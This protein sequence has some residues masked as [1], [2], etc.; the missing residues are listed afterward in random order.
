MKKITTILKNLFFPSLGGARGGYRGMVCH[1]FFILSFFH[2]FILSAQTIG[3]NV[4][5]GGN[6]GNVDGKATVT[7]MGG[8]IQNVFGGARMANVGERTFV[9][10]DGAHA[11]G[12]IFITNVFAGNDIAGTIGKSDELPAQLTEILTGLQTQETQPEKN[13]ISNLWNAFIRVTRN[14]ADGKDNLAVIIGSLYGGGNGDYDY[15]HEHEGGKVKHLVY[16]KNDHSVPIATRYTNEGE[17]DFPRPNLARTYL[18]LKGGLIAHIYGGG[19]NATITENTTISLNNES[20]DLE[21]MLARYAANQKAK[22]PSL[23]INEVITETLDY[24]KSRVQLSNFQADFS[25][26]AFNSAR[27]FGGNNKAPMDIRPTWNLQKGMVRDLYS[28]GNEG[29]MTCPEGLLLE[30]KPT[31]ANNDHLIIQN[32][33]GGCRRANVRPV[34]SN[35]TEV[36]VANLPGYNFPVGLSARTLVRGGKITNVYGGNDISGNVYGGN[37]IG[38]Y[39]SI[40]GDVYGGGNGG[41]FYTDKEELKNDLNYRDFYYSPE[42]ASSYI[43]ALNNFR[44]HAEQVSIYLKGSAEDK[45]TIIGGSVFCGGNCA[46]LETNKL[47]PRVE[48]KIGNHVIADRVFLG[49]NGQ[50]MTDPTILGYYKNHD[51]SSIQLTDPSVFARYMDGVTMTLKPSVIFDADYMDNKSMIGSFYCGGNVGS[52]AIPGKTTIDFDRKLIIYD[53]LVGGCNSADVAASDGLNAAYSG[54]LLGAEDERGTLPN[55]FF[56]ED[57][58][59]GG[60]IKDRLEINLSNI[61]ITPKRWRIERDAYGTYQTDP[62]T[63]EYIRYKDPVT[64][65]P[66]LEWNTVSWND[67]SNDFTITST[68]GS[69]VDEALRLEGG[70]VFGGCY[71]SGHVNGNVIINVNKDLINKDDVF[72]GGKSN[73]DY[74]GQRDDLMVLAM[75]VFGGGYGEETEIW[76]STDINLKNNAYAFQIFGGGVMGVV[77]KKNGI[78]QYVYDERYSTHVNLLGT[79]PGTESGLTAESEYL[80]GGGNEGL[81]CGNS[82]VNLHNG[83]IYDAFGGSSNSDVLGHTEVI[84]GKDGGFPWVRDNIYG[85]NDFGGTVRGAKDFSAV[86]SRPVSD[87]TLLTAATYVRYIQGH[88]GNNI[89]GGNYGSYDYTQPMFN[90]YTWTTAESLPDGKKLGDPKEGFHFPHLNKNSFVHFQPS[91]NSDNAV[92]NAVFGSSEGAAGLT[93]LNNAMQNETYVLIDDTETKDATRFSNMDIFGGGAYAGVG[94]EEAVGAGRTLVDLFAGSFNNVYGGSNQEALIGYTR[95]NVPAESTVKVNALYGGSKG[96]DPAEVAANPILFGRFC[97]TYITCIDYKSPNARVENGIYGGNRNSRLAFDTYIN[98][99]APVYQSNGYM[100]EIYGGGYG[101]ETVS[102][103]TN[104]YMNNGSNAYKVF[105]GGRDGNVFNFTSVTY[106]LWDQFKHEY[107]GDQDIDTKVQA[108]VMRYADF[109]TKFRTYV[110]EPGRIS[111]PTSIPAYHDNI[112]EWGETAA[113]IPALV[114]TKEYHNTNV[115]LLEG[116]N[117]TGYAY[118]G[119]FGSDAVVAGTTYLELKGGNVEK[120]IYGGGQGGPVMD[121]YNLINEPEDYKHFTASTHVYIEGGMARNVYGGGYEGH[122]GKHEGGISDSNAGDIPGATNVIVGT[123]DGTTFLSGIPAIQRNLYGGGEGGSVYGTSNITLNNG[124]IGYRYKNTGTESDPVYEYKEELD[125]RTPNAIEMAGNVFG[126]GYVINSY[127]DNANIDM[128]GGIVRGSMYG[129]GEV[130]P[131]G[132]GTVKSGATTAHGGI[133]NEG[134]TIYKAGKTHVRMFNG[135]VLRNVFGGGRGKD[136]WGGDGTMYMDKDLVATLDMECKGFVFGQ[137]EVDIHGGEIGTDEGMA[138]GYGNVFG[139]C[140]EGTVYSAYEDGNGVLCYGKKEGARYDD[141]YEGYYFK[142]ENGAFPTVSVPGDPEPRRIFTEDCKVLVEPW[143]QV[144]GSPIAYDAKTYNA[145]DYI[146]IG[147]LNTLPA[148]AKDDAIWPSEWNTVDVGTEVTLE[149]DTKVFRERGIHIH[150]AVFAGGNIASGSS[151]LYANAK[152]IFGNATASIHDVYNRDFITIGTGHTGGLYGDGNLT[153]VDGYRELNITNYGSDLY[154][155]MPTLSIGEYKLLPKREQDYYEVKYKCIK[156]EGCSDLEGTTY[157]KD[158][159]LPLDELIALFTNPD[160]TSAKIKADGSISTDGTGTEVLT[161]NAAGYLVVPNPDIWEENGVVSTY[162]GRI[163]NTIQRADFCGVFGSRMVMKGAQDR[164]P[165]TV[166]YTNYTINRVREV[167]LNKM[168]SPASD[169]GINALHGNYFGIYSVVNYLGALTSDVNFHTTVRTTET[170]DAAG[171]GLAP[172]GKTFEQW[173][174]A[175]ITNKKRNNGNCYN[176]LALASGVYLELTTEKSTG[177]TLETK[178]WGLIT[179]VIELDLINVQP[180]IGGGFVYAKNEHGK[181][182]IVSGHPK[183]PMNTLNDGAASQWDYGYPKDRTDANQEVWQTS[184]NFIHSSQTIIDDCYNITNRY[185]GANRVPAHYWYVSGTVYVYD[186]YISAYTGAPNAYSETVEIPITLSAASNGKMTLMDVQPNRYAYYSSY[187]NQTT[188]TRLE[189]EKKVIINDVEYKLN[190]PIS[191]WDWKKLPKS[192]QALFV[193]NTYV[194]TKDCKIGTDEYAAGTVLLE[195]QY[196]DLISDDGDGNPVYPTV[197]EE[198]EGVTQDVPFLE[199]FHSSNNISHQTGYILSYNVSNPQKWDQWYTQIESNTRNKQQTPMDGYHEG[200]TYHPIADGIYGQQEYKVADIINKDTYTTYQTAVSTHDGLVL[201]GQAAFERAYVTTSYV[202]VTPKAEGSAELHMQR[203]SALAESEYDTGVWSSIPKAEAYV[204]TGTIQLSDEKYIYINELFTAAEKADI[205]SGI[206]SKITALPSVTS[207]DQTVESL[208]EAQKTA[209]GPE[210]IRQLTSYIDL[211]KEVDEKIV[212]AYYCTRAG[213]YGG[214]YY[215]ATHNYRALN[216][217][218]AMSEADRKKFTFNYDALDLLIDPTYGRK[219][220]GAFQKEGTKYQYDSDKEGAVTN[221]AGYSLTKPINYTATYNGETQDTA[222]NGI[223]L[224][225]DVEYTSEQFESLPNEQRHY[226]ALIVPAEG[227]TVYVVKEDFVHIETP[228]AIGLVLSEEQYGK[229]TVEERSNIQTLIFPE[230][231]DETTYYYCRDGYTIGENT[232][233]KTPGVVTGITGATGGITDGKVAAGTIISAA[234]YATLP[235]WQQNFTIHGES[236]METST[237]Y[238]SR[239]ADINDLSSEKIITVIYKYDYEESDESGLHITPVS[240]RH[241]VNIHINFRTGIPIVEDIKEPE[242]ILPG[243]S[244]TMR[245]PTVRAGAYEVLGGGW[246]IFEKESYAESHIYGK[247]YTPSA[248]PLYWYQDGYM[249][250]YYAK[251]YLG[252]TYSNAVPIS[253]ANYHDLKRVMEDKETHLHVDY[254]RNRLKRDSKIYINNYTGDEDGLDYL[255]DFYDLSLI[256]GTGGGYTV[257][258]DKITTTGEGANA[259]LAGHTLLNISETEG[260]NIHDGNTYKEGVKGAENLQ[261][262]LRSD[263]SHTGIW[264][265]IGSNDQCFH[266]NL[267]GDGHTISGLDHSLFYNLCGS[268]YNL[269]VTGSFSTAGVVDKGIGYVESAWVKTT[270]TPDG[271]VRAVFGAPNATSGYRQLVNSYCQTGKTYLTTDEGSHGLA[272]PMEEKAF[273]NGTLAY[274]LNN[275]YLY[276]RYANSMGEVDEKIKRARYFTI[277]EDNKLTLQ[278]YRKYVNNPALCSSGYIYTPKGTTAQD[279]LRY[280][281]ERFADGDFRYAAGEIPTED[282][283]RMYTDIQKNENGVVV[284]KTVGFYPIWPDDYIF[285]GQKLTYGYS[286]TQAHQ[287]VPTAIVRAGGRISTNDNGN[288]VYRAPAYYGSKVMGV[289]HFNPQVNLAAKSSDGTKEAYPGMTAIDFAGH[290]DPAYALGTTSAPWFYPPLL[291][292]DGLQSISNRDETKNLLVYAPAEEAESGYFNKKT[293]D[294]LNDYFI[295][296]DFDGHYD[297]AGGYRMVGKNTTTVYGHLVDN[298]LTATTDHLL[299]DKEDFNAP[300]AYTFDGSHRMWYQRT[301]EDNEYVNRTIG[302]QGISIPFT[303]ELV[304]TN[305]K[306]E[307]THFYDGSEASQNGT[308]IGHEYWLRELED[309]TATGEPETVTANF[310]YPALPGAPSA[311]TNKTVENTFLWDYYYQATG[312]HDHQDKNQDIYQTYYRNSRTYNNYPLLT[313]SKPYIL[314]LPG[315]TYYEFDLSGNFIAQNAFAPVDRLEKQTVTFA[316]ETGIGISVSDDEIL[317]AKTLATKNGYAFVPSYSRQSIA[318]GQSTYTLTDLGGSYDKVPATGAATIVDA[319]R[320]YFAA[321]PGA[322]AREFKGVRSIRF[323]NNDSGKLNPDEELGGKDRGGLE[324]FAKGRNIYTISFMEKSVDI[325]IVNASG[326]TLTTFTLEPGKTVITPITNPGTYIVNKKKVFVK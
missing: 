300:I 20:D 141:R 60:Q 197:T 204:C 283:E 233:G 293:Y 157:K 69:S 17:A 134:A 136:S 326:A 252:K 54:G 64:G 37:A 105:G 81:V 76:G 312:V 162:A 290:N 126:G 194:V 110:S 90:K 139:G 148:K 173:K 250:A 145:G 156:A 212:E 259:H 287:D 179:G 3:G 240:E 284:N 18:E 266:G 220:N 106:W 108:E 125:D 192:E 177:K 95:V 140:D 234:D 104:I 303:A 15:E 68:S 49:N 43:D 144:K 190:D 132:R 228:Y 277:G 77:G 243:T 315:Q 83:R 304:T 272:T 47:N 61:T 122:V 222:H 31:P 101:V 142:Y 241:I 292:D 33:Y 255:R 298:D 230:T 48:L 50:K 281:E 317:S 309:I 86:T 172:D 75:S 38:I 188:N 32:V 301:P 114:D 214:D 16:N 226:A 147:Y 223:T 14:E 291:D 249:L 311:T 174:A 218:S 67:D 24:L 72:G 280:V 9:H 254:D 289:A 99:D 286:A 258:D 128:Y 1:I 11:T 146:P 205:I 82:Y 150:N 6:E 30:I 225:K 186:Q 131:I 181:H 127:V 121:E 232:E 325:R 5:G 138:N 227:G 112:W 310:L 40:L 36:Q 7:V 268:V 153:F 21:S 296:S 53:K 160:G 56:T 115:H 143:L 58:T 22:D 123:K 163:M 279:T 118:G 84:I 44:P 318:A 193:E 202:E 269:G 200:P 320:P 267:H 117:V 166:D 171:K 238:V 206:N 87:P 196:N 221:P 169:T 195:S 321:A 45:P 10:I 129:G 26:L 133:V 78:G 170:A 251:T 70:N 27:V 161:R 305:D 89:F 219:S 93:Y 28:G 55:E 12:D 65:L 130:G 62:K 237:L 151:S 207:A 176:Q 316:S 216:A 102:G 261:F 273:Y 137:T 185:M 100:G 51:I 19:N 42:G 39:T 164:V 263:I 242:I 98:I 113:G 295:D 213:L 278:P 288:R 231:G 247:E 302:W 276:K 314:G 199:A 107:A 239:G 297:Y 2:S 154:H 152:T 135:H 88:V 313:A 59:E 74:E 175:N 256:S 229:L 201:T 208:T 158:A 111:L 264:S 189:G 25:N 41:Y 52:M 96:Y 168:E 319:F 322:P 8:D 23:D 198:I 103:R 211:K 307:I 246:E 210:G 165:E 79:N 191:Y 85:G 224:T 91:D 180:G 270:G 119:G 260:T 245:V 308:K 215:L 274:D 116:S 294:V 63:G 73:V 306:G 149:D 46:T 282:D 4:Y 271:S 167:S 324:I 155:I 109:L 34:D 235:N 257:T 66:Q 217:W 71:N 209:L 253:V 285:F 29:D 236:P 203:G 13:A 184:G 159:T 262:Y 35:G 92:G 323:S 248:D 97:D 94:S 178:D 299:I 275:F 183:K 187:V 80:Y 124:Y 120:D 182:D 57:G 244:I 265:P